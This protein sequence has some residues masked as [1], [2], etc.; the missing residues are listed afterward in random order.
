VQAHIFRF[1][2]VYFSPETQN[3]K[4]IKAGISGIRERER[5]R[6]REKGKR[7]GNTRKHS[8]S[9]AERKE[10]VRR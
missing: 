5:E 10:L 3:A 4:F 1:A 7:K 8:E 2:G 9:L 6:E